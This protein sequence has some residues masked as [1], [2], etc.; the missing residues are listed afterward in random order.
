MTIQAARPYQVFSHTNQG[1][2]HPQR[3]NG[4]VDG[5]L[6]Q[7]SPDLPDTQQQQLKQAVLKNQA[8]AHGKYFDSAQNSQDVAA[9]Y[10]GVKTDFSSMDPK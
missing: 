8:S 9:Y 4:Q 2:Q 7:H 10:Q 5:F 3:S 1:R 6:R